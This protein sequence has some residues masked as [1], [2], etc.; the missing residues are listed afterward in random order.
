MKS[1]CC[2]PRTLVA[3]L[4]L[5]LLL[6][7]C[8]TYTVIDD[9]RQLFGEGRGEESL[10]LLDKAAKEPDADPAIRMEYDRQRAMLTLQWLSQAEA[11]RQAKQFRVAEGLYQRVLKYD[12]DNPRAREGLKQSRLDLRNRALIK[13]A[14]KLAAAGRYPE[15]GRAHV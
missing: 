6:G 10:A 2:A 12:P 11:M 9:A 14:E 15:I 5:C 7:A 8:A 1:S 13:E 4:A 3:G